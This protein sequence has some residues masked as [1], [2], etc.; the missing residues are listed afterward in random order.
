MKNQ[1]IERLKLCID[2]QKKRIVYRR[3]INKLNVIDTYI[4]SL[5]NSHLKLFN[6]LKFKSVNIDFEKVWLL[7]DKRNDKQDA[8]LQWR[9][10]TDE[11]REAALKHIPNYVKSTPDKSKRLHLHRYLRKKAFNNEI[12]YNKD[13]VKAEEQN[14]NN[15]KKVWLTG[16]E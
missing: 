16:D 7:Y 13:Y 6:T 8:E 15:Q 1:D 12:I 4:L 9:K 3:S 5:L 11:E 14:K 10:L 2:Y